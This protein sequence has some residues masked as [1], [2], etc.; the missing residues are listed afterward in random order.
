METLTCDVFTGQKKIGYFS[1]R[2]PVIADQADNRPILLTSRFLNACTDQEN[3]KTLQPHISLS[4]TEGVSKVQTEK[5]TTDPQKF[6]RLNVFLQMWQTF[7]T[8]FMFLIYNDLQSPT[9][10]VSCSVCC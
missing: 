3:F 10:F 1:F 6:G 9:L 8:L 4:F 7:K 5:K 2:S